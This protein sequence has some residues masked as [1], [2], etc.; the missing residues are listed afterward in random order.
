MADGAGCGGGGG[1]PTGCVSRS[2]SVDE[3]DFLSGTT[4]RVTGGT[5]GL[6]GLPEVGA[7]EV[8]VV[9][10]GVAV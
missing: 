9:P 10:P 1:G 2:R 7:F 8:V 3:A 6:G 4:L 5:G